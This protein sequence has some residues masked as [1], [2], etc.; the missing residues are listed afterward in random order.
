MGKKGK[1]KD[2]TAGMTE[3]EK[4]R[5][6]EQVALEE[7]QAKA[8]AAQIAQQFLKDKL[9]SEMKSVK[10]NE[11]KLIVKWRDILRQQKAD[12]L[13]KDIQ[14]LSQTF[15]RIMDR[16]NSV[17]DAL[18]KDLEDAE[19]QHRLIARQHDTNLEKVKKLHNLRINALKESFLNDVEDLSGEIGQEKDT[20]MDKHHGEMQELQ[21]VIFAMEQIFQERSQ[22]AAQEFHSQKDEIKNYENEEKTALRCQVE[23]NMAAL[24]KQFQ[25]ALNQ[26]NLD[27]A[28]RRADFNRLKTK[29]DANSKDIDKQMKKI[30]KIQENILKLKEQM[31]NNAKEA[32]HQNKTLKETYE[33]M[34]L[35]YRNRK[36]KM[37]LQREKEK[38]KLTKITLMSNKAIK[39]LTETKEKSEK[40]LRVSEMCRKM[41]TEEEKVLPFYSSSVL[42]E[43]EK[44]QMETEANTQTAEDQANLKLNNDLSFAKNLATVSDDYLPMENFW[45]RY[46]KVLLDKLALKKEQNNLENENANLRQILKQYLDGISVNEET[47]ASSNPL[48]VVNNR[49]NVNLEKEGQ[50]KSGSRTVVEAAHIVN[51]IL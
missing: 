6:L 43:E 24:F 26:Y 35:H 47:L 19:S 14:I 44:T 51:N 29:D 23:D 30:Q 11:T 39:H 20:I 18:V 7:A 32:E 10:L 31:S 17:I 1:K 15:E 9:G 8:Q 34:L 25:D 3:E 48:F 21:D 13:K 28:E 45:K 46:N 4:M 37:N 2:P 16:K 22:D 33:N 38:E 40:I 27:T 50:G 12:E 42:T 41:E 5:Y 49:T 36:S